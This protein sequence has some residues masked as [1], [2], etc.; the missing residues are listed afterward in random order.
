MLMALSI[1]YWW[2]GLAME[3]TPMRLVTSA[4]VVRK[5][6]SWVTDFQQVVILFGSVSR[7]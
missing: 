3:V 5:A 4:S 1:R 2:N 6:V 7:A